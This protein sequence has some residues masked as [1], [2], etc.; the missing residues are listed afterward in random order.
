[1]TIKRLKKIIENLPDDMRIY[2][3]DGKFGTFSNNSEFV[4]LIPYQNM[5]VLQKK[6]DFDVNNEVTSHYNAAK[7][8]GLDAN[9]FW[10]EFYELG[11]DY[12][13]FADPKMK[14]EAF[15]F[16]EKQI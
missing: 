11:Y 5:A 15:D 14:E 16:L 1:M 3:D 8:N 10:N 13:D 12:D 4:L 2:A 6:S 7:R 9:T